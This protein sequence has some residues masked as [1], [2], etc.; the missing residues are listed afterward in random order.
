MLSDMLVKQLIIMIYDISNSSKA[1]GRRNR[2]ME[3][4]TVATATIDTKALT[5]IYS[6]KRLSTRVGRAL[7]VKSLRLII[8]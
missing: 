4:L 8:A 2:S 1:M 3:V 6:K 7:S 5:T